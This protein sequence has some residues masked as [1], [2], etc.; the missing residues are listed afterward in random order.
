MQHFPD[1]TL[2][3]FS[4]LLPHPVELV[5]PYE[6]AVSEIMYPNNIN[7]ISHGKIIL[8]TYPETEDQATL[9]PLQKN[10]F[11]FNTE[12]KASGFK[13]KFKTSLLIDHF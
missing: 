6:V 11:P 10:T 13:F 4:T 1:N 7:L 3:T 12:G 9:H 5:G 8:S 2:S